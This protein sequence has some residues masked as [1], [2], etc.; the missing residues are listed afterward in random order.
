MWARP[1]IYLTREKES[2]FVLLFPK[3]LK[4]P[5]KFFNFTRM[6]VESFK[7]LL[8]FVEPDIALGMVMVSWVQTFKNTRSFTVQLTTLLTSTS[9]S[10]LV[11]SSDI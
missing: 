4:H 1:L 5:E 8:V 11:S 10:L 6:S 7:E 9:S 3:L 2:Q